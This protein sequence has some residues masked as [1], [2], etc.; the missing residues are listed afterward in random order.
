MRRKRTKESP[1]LTLVR[2]GAGVE[3][4]GSASTIYGPVRA[5]LTTSPKTI[6]V[7]A[8]SESLNSLEKEVQ[9]LE[10]R[11]YEVCVTLNLALGVLV[12]RNLFGKETDTIDN[13]EDNK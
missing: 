3:E 2:G 13:E 10:S 9:T 5:G 1:R 4:N 12:E 11:F 6:K 7:Q 8:L